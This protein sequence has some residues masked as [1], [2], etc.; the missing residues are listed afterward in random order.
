MKGLG[1]AFLSYHGFFNTVTL[2]FGANEVP[3]NPA[4]R[5]KN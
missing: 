4:K 2:G 1:E 3:L 5:N